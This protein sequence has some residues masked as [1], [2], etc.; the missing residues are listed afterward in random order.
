M[1]IIFGAENAE[2]VMKDNKYIV[3]E[4]DTVRPEA[5]RDPVVAY[6]IVNTISLGEMG[7]M[8][9]YIDWHKDLINDYKTK[10][11]DECLQTIQMLYGHFNGELD[12]FYDII[13][14]RIQYYKEND[15]GKEW[16]GVWEAWDEEANQL[17]F[18][19]KA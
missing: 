12:S 2:M 15:P 17:I 11:W 14:R 1:N 9:A 19:P 5:H 6:A 3:L 16:Q 4:L 18:F 8:P 13:G 10:K 7:Q